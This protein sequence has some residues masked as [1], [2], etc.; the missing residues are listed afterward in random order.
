MKTIVVPQYENLKLEH[1]WAWGEEQGGLDKYFPIQHERKKLPRRWWVA[2]MMYSIFGE[3]FS[4]WVDD[5]CDARNAKLK[6]EADF[7]IKM[8]PEVKKAFEKSTHV[9]SRYSISFLLRALI[10]PTISFLKALNGAGVNMLKMGVSRRRTKAEIR[11]AKKEAEL[12]E[13]EI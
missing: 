1:I 3:P 8:D 13:L 5:R 6:Q 7:D 9:S 12:K 2:N 4:Q 10:F 11:A